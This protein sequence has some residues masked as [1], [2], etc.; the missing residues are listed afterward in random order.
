MLIG[1]ESPVVG[2]EGGKQGCPQSL[3]QLPTIG[4]HCSFYVPE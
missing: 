3:V 2:S 4:S 1:E